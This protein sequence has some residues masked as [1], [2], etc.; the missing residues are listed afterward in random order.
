V[1]WFKQSSFQKIFEQIQHDGSIFHEKN[2]AG[3]DFWRSLKVNFI[4]I[5]KITISLMI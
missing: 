3:D 2:P 1:F 4:L 5:M